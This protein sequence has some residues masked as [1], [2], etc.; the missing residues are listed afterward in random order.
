LHALSLR[1]D[2]LMQLILERLTKEISEQIA[3]NM[4]EA[5]IY[6]AD[7]WGIINNKFMDTDNQV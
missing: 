5:K 2:P 1:P 6:T 4:N 3:V 7:C